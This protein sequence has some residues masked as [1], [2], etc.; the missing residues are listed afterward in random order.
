M[1]VHKAGVNLLDTGAPFYDTYQCSDGGYIAVGAL[2]AH[3][4]ALMRDMLGLQDEA[5]MQLETQMNPKRWPEMRTLLTQ[6]FA[7]RSRNE[8]AA[9]FHQTDACVTPVMGMLEVMDHPHNEDRGLL[10]QRPG[11][12][13]D[14]DD[15]RHKVTASWEP[16]AAPRLQR[17]PAIA[18]S[19]APM[20]VSGQH[21][22]EVFRQL[23]FSDDRIT[24]ILD[25]SN[26]PLKKKWELKPDV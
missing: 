20:P 14:E 8:W 23:G 16:V 22:E 5:C 9:L 15:G 6:T 11:D 18:P 25:Q 24:E 7:T 2:E 10:W 17:T 21:T 4:F 12:D 1:W 26:Q 3:F 13:Q 19:A